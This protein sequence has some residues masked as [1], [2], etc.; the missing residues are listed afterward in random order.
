MLR[1]FVKFWLPALVW[2]LIIFSASSDSHSSQHSSCF[3]EPLLRWLFPQM[4]PARVEAIHFA[5]R[6]ACHLTE[7]AI[8]AL[9]FWRGIR[10]PVR[11]DSRAWNWSEAGLALALVLLFAA[12]DEIHQVF[13]P[14]RTGQTSDVFI[15][16]TGGAL[17][18]LAL[19]I[20]HKLLN[21]RR[22]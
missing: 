21:R 10:Q 6:K 15:D 5:F 22:T 3:F 13:V 19:R 8:L 12:S 7:Y 1:S 11:N 4:P 20:G 14:S 17:G 9:L 18:L 2:M 16:A